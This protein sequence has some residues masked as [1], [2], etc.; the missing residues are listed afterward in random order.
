M[1]G[2]NLTEEEIV[3]RIS[4]YQAFS[5]TTTKDTFDKVL[6]RDPSDIYKQAT[7]LY[8]FKTKYK[9]VNKFGITQFILIIERIHKKEKNFIKNLFFIVN[10]RIDIKL[11]R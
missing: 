2:N 11:L 8:L 4:A 5:I 7:N 6:N 10:S 9:V 3:K 1:V